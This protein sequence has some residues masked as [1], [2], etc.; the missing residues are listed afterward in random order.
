MMPSTDWLKG[1]SEALAERIGK[2]EQ[3]IR[4]VRKGIDDLM[5]EMAKLEDRVKT[6]EG[7]R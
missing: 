3:E 6:L 2:L 5:A 7:S 1:F 4:F